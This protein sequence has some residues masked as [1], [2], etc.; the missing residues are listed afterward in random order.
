M[1]QVSDNRIAALARLSLDVLAAEGK[2]I[3][4]RVALTEC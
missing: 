3:Y 4:Q 1:S 2:I